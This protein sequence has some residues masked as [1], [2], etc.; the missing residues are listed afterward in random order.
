MHDLYMQRASDSRRRI[1]LASPS[2]SVST[3]FYKSSN[4]IKTSTGLIRDG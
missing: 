2:P 3:F 4:L 1:L